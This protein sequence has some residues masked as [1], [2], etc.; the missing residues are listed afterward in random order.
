M[1]SRLGAV[2]PTLQ[3]VLRAN[4]ENERLTREA[5]GALRRGADAA[6]MGALLTRHHEEL[7]SHLGISHPEIDRLLREGLAA[8]AL[9]G[10]ING[11]GGGGSFFL[12]CEGNA[13]AVCDLY[14]A[15]GLRAWIVTPGPGL[16]VEVGEGR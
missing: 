5:L 10:K 4:R 13:P 16:Q 11:S 6:E 7:S 8:G 2:D 12:L 1:I 14:K 15:M 9:G 3:G